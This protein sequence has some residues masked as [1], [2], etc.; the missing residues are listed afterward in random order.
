MRRFFVQKKEGYKLMFISL[1][2][3]KFN[4]RNLVKDSTSCLKEVT[5]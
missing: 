2:I 4:W 3:L 1:F 5:D